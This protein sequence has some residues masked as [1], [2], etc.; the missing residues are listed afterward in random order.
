MTSLDHNVYTREISKGNPVLP[1]NCF[2]ISL[3][4]SSLN[5][6]VPLLT[7]LLTLDVLKAVSV[8][9]FNKSGDDQLVHN[10]EILLNEN[11]ILTQNTDNTYVH[12]KHVSLPGLSLIKVQPITLFATTL[13]GPK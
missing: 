13:L 4:V 7:A 6:T 12:Y 2:R 1:R 5:E 11:G 3:S 10:G 8:M 9:V